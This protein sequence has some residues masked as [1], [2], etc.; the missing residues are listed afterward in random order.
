MVHLY[1]QNYK[2]VYV[3]GGGVVATFSGTVSLIG[4]RVKIRL[5]SHKNRK[6]W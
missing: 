5:Y 2:E 3:V 1:E 4:D 6:L